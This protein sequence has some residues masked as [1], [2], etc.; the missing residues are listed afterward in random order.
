LANEN[1]TFLILDVHYYEHDDKEYAQVAGVR[2]CGVA[3]H[4][5]LSCHA[6]TVGNIAVLDPYML[7]VWV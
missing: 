3:S 4:D 6:L 1:P 7:L 2:F 5:V